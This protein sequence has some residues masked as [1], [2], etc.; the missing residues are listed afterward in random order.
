MDTDNLERR[1]AEKQAELEKRLAKLER[2]QAN[3][4]AGLKQLMDEDD[5]KN[6]R[7]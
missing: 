1:F 7:T 4:E 5:R 2:W 6:A 3:L